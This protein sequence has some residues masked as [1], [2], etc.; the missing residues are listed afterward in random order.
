MN[1]TKHLG[2]G[3]HV[4]KITV[5]KATIMLVGGLAE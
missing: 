1:T 4:R 5:S 3:V 2:G